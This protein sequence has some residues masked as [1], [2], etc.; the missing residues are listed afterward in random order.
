MAHVLHVLDLIGPDHVGIGADWDGGGGVVDM[1]DV[2]AVP[3]ITQRLLQEGYSV[4]DI[5]KIW[6]KNV[7]RLLLA[8]ADHAAREAAR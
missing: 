8:A 3:M 6:S 2:A 4:D 5:E 1:R 7:L